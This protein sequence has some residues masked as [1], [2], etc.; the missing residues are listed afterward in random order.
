MGRKNARVLSALLA[1]GMV[2]GTLPVGA[3]APSDGG[4]KAPAIR[5]NGTKDLIN[6]T[7]NSLLAE[8]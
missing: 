4:Y 2:F 8:G 1:A 5:F 6:A 3:S 7:I